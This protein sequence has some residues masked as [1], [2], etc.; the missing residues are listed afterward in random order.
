MYAVKSPQLAVFHVQDRYL[1]IKNAHIKDVNVSVEGLE[2]PGKLRV[3]ESFRFKIR[4][5]DIRHDEHTCLSLR[6]VEE[7]YYFKLPGDDGRYEEM[8]LWVTVEDSK[9][10]VKDRRHTELEIK[11]EGI[12]ANDRAV[13]HGLS[14]PSGQN[15]N[16]RTV[17][18]GGRL[19]SGRFR[20]Y[21]GDGKPRAVK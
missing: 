20:V 12:Q 17:L 5:R 4:S 15:L 11:H 2:F 8:L 13:I 6:Y 21:L 7:Y 18:L 10:N 3:G 14:T 19:P 9:P 16:G 1:C